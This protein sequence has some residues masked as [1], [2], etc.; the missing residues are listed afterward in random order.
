M[1]ARPA[2]RAMSPSSWP[3][4]SARSRIPTISA[5]Q[6]PPPTVTRAPAA[7]AQP[8]LRITSERDAM[9]CSSG[10]SGAS[11]TRAPIRPDAVPVAAIATASP[12]A[13]RQIIAVSMSSRASASAASTAATSVTSEPAA[14]A[15]AT[16]L[17]A[18]ASSWARWRVVTSRVAE[19]SCSPSGPSETRRTVVSSHERSPARRRPR[20]TIVR[21]RPS[22]STSANVAAIAS[23]SP[24]CTKSSSRHPRAAKGA[25]SS[26]LR[27][28]GLT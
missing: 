7:V 24:P 14:T 18:A 25:W 17:V 27:L 6:V 26:T 15:S 12:S 9:R 4:A 8:D 23:R 28:A 19:M 11:G 10:P 5:P 22:A 2:I 20:T 13:N 21:S 1:D 16:R 3:D